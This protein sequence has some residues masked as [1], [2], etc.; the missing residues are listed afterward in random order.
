MRRHRE[1]YEGTNPNR[2][3]GPIL[4]HRKLHMPSFPFVHSQRLLCCAL[5]CGAWS[6]YMYAHMCIV[7]HQSLLLRNSIPVN[8]D[9]LT[10]CWRDGSTVQNI[11]CSYREHGFYSQ[12]PLGSSQLS[13]T[14]DLRAPV[15]SSDLQAPAVHMVHRYTNEQR[16]MWN[17]QA[18]WHTLVIPLQRRIHIDPWCCDQPGRVGKFQAREKP[19]LKE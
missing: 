11:C 1:C 10:L 6:V 7:R 5:F 18:W 12:H 14:S 8:P 13:M 16:T 19:Y 4:S 15:P 17:R 3:P 9:Y 2:I